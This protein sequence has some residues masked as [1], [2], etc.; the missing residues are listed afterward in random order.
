MIALFCLLI[1]AGLIQGWMWLYRGDLN[2]LL[3]GQC[4]KLNQVQFAKQPER[5]LG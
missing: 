4:N 5:D 3:A 2:G 1:T